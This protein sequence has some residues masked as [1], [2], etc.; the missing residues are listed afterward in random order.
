VD[1]NA[2]S[3]ALLAENKTIRPAPSKG[4]RQ[5]DAELERLIRAG[6]ITPD[7]ALIHAVDPSSLSAKFS[8]PAKPRLR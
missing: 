6:V 3:L 8:K 1:E 5:I 7:V 2:S 4:S